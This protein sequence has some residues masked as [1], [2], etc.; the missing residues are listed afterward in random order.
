VHGFAD[1]LN[2]IANTKHPEHA[3]LV[4]WSGGAY[5]PEAFDPK[6]VVFDDPRRRW[7]KAFQE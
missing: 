5:D 7:K 1:F 2:A 3:E 4:E 6:R